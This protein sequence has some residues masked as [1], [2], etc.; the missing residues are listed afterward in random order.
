MRSEGS[1]KYERDGKEGIKTLEGTCVLNLL[2]SNSQ[3]A[4]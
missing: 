4:T 3:I 2:K 1:L